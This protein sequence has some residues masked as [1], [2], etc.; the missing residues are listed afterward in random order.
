LLVLFLL[1]FGNFM[2]LGEDTHDRFIFSQQ[3]QL[4]AIILQGLLKGAVA[5]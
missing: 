5:R 2:D 4:F 3:F 1:V